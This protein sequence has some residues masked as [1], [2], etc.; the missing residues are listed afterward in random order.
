M[1]RERTRERKGLL[2][3]FVRL[4]LKGKERGTSFLSTAGIE[5][6]KKWEGKRKC[7]EEEEESKEKKEAGSLHLCRE[8]KERKKGFFFLI[9]FGLIDFG[10]KEI[11]NLGF[12]L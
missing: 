4:N 5:R 9:L 7:F 11:M 1:N 2:L 8:Q 12:Y 6:E 3:M 10:M